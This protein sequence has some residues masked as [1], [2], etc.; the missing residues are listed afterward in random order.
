[1]ERAYFCA[2]GW[3][4]DNVPEADWP[5]TQQHFRKRRIAL[6]THRVVLVLVLPFVEIV[7]LL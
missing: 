1:M 5:R 4:L 7:E 2:R 6:S 3:C